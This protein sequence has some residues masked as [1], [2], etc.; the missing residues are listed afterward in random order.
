MKHKGVYALIISRSPCCRADLIDTFIEHHAGDSESWKVIA[1]EPP[2][3]LPALDRLTLTS[4]EIQHDEPVTKAAAH[5]M[6]ESAQIRSPDTMAT[7]SQIK[8]IEGYARRAAFLLHISLQAMSSGNYPSAQ[9]R[10]D[11]C[12][13]ALQSQLDVLRT[14]NRNNMR[15]PAPKDML[16][17]EESPSTDSRMS[18]GIESATRR[19]ERK[20]ISTPHELDVVERLGAVCGCIGDCY[21]SDGDI[22]SAL[23]EYE[24]AAAQLRSVV[25]GRGPASEAAQQLSITLNKIG[26]SHHVSGD[27]DA[28]IDYYKSALKIRKERLEALEKKT[29]GNPD[30]I[31]LDDR[32]RPETE[33]PIVGTDRSD[34]KEAKGKKDSDT[35]VSCDL[36]PSALLDVAINDVKIADALRS[37]G[38]EDQISQAGVHF[39]S[40]MRALQRCR[41]ME[42][43][44]ASLGFS[45]KQR[46]EALESYLDSMY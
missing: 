42:A 12:R 20:E 18:E 19:D 6:E 36:I 11:L 46:F 24:E 5:V 2:G 38:K 23:Q 4:I 8:S 41:A 26:E 37:M 15:K 27:I 44:V 39:M 21:R 30:D 28:A 22:S 17:S 34:R 40:A 25:E 31:D 3:D 33:P 43:S 7:S 16:A 29:D 45:G 9:A 32:H 10:L 13:K 14:S 35:N 1:D